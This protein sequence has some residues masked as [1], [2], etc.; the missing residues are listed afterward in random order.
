[1]GE[2]ALRSKFWFGLGASVMLYERGGMKGWG[3]V[4]RG[5]DAA[6]AGEDIY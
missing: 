6:T 2:E 4:Y 3:G 5:L 1:M